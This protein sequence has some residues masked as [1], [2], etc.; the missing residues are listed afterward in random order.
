M[1]SVVATGH[2]RVSRARC[3]SKSPTARKCASLIWSTQELHRLPFGAACT[4]PRVVALPSALGPLVGSSTPASEANSV[5]KL[6][7]PILKAELQVIALLNS[8]P[9]ACHRIAAAVDDVAAEEWAKARDLA[10]GNASVV[11]ANGMV[12]APSMWQIRQLCVRS[13]VPFVGFGFFD[14]M[15]MLTVGG[16]IENTIGVAFCL[17]SLAAAGMGQMVSDAA[18]ITLQGLIERFADKLGLPHP[19]LT[20]QQQQL[21]SVQSWA[22]ASRIF[23]IVLGCSFGMFP[24]LLLAEAP[25]QGAAEQIAEKLSPQHRDEFMALVSSRKFSKNEKVL[26]FSEIS[27]YMLFIESGE[28]ECKGRDADGLPFHVCTLERGHSFGKPHLHCQSRV[29]LVAMGNDVVVQYIEKD[30]FVRLTGQEGMEVLESTQQAEL[31]V[32]FAALGSQ[33][34]E[35]VGSGVQGNGNNRMLATLPHSDELKR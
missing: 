22:L 15:I 6:T 2:P 20:L 19:K 8:D 16:A 30:D 33:V 13:A 23:G 31:T 1:A 26:E 7:E 9:A 12:P 25:R 5:Q 32:Y 11:A 14:N 4:L 24:L 21:K 17:S 3:A 27:N 35:P 29:D 34:N 28:V 10:Q 18:G